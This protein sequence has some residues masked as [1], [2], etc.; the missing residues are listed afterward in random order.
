MS[1]LPLRI[2]NV[3][4][5]NRTH[6]VVYQTVSIFAPN[7]VRYASCIGHGVVAV[8]NMYIAVGKWGRPNVGCGRLHM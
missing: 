1:S 8:H 4:T 5:R 6:D 3:C 7:G 2:V